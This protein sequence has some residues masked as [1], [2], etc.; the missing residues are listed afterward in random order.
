MILPI[1]KIPKKTIIIIV[2]AMVRI[3][4]IMLA[5]Q[6]DVQV[7]R[8]VVEAGAEAGRGHGGQG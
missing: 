1:A 2:V 5:H 6:I 4:R 7:V 8:A 3:A